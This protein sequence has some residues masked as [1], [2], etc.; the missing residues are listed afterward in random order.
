MKKNL[1]IIVFLITSTMFPQSIIEKDKQLH[2][3]AGTVFGALG[4]DLI[5][6]RTKNT[7]QAIWGG[8]ALASAAGISKE[9]VD[10]RVLNQK[11]DKNDLFATVLG[12]ITISV[13]IPLFKK[14]VRY[15]QL[16]KWNGGYI[17]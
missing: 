4:Y 3:A 13:T 5:W 12:G 10:A 2:F 11:L 8:I 9:L 15:R 7:K 6:Q 1:L 14:K 17:H 16:D